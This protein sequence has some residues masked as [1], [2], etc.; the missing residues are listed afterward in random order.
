MKLRPNTLITLG[1]SAVF[2]LAAVFLARGWINNSVEAEFRTA[3]TLSEAVKVPL[4]K[5]ITKPIVVADLNLNFGDTLT[6]DKL[7]VVEY[8]EN[9]IPK[10]AYTNIDDLLADM[11]RRV[12]REH[13]ARFEPI[14]PHKISG[15]NGRRALSQLIAPGMRAA[16]FRITPTSGVGGYIL[17]NDRVDVVFVR[18][19]V[20]DLYALEKD[21]VVTKIVMQNVKV[22]GVDL[23]SNQQSETTALRQSV[24]LE[25]NNEQAQKL[26][27][28]QNSGEL[29]L[30]LR[31]AGEADIAPE[32]TAKLK[33]I[34]NKFVIQSP[35]LPP[36]A[37]ASIAQHE[38]NNLPQVTIIRGNDRNQISVM[39]D[40]GPLEETSEIKAYQ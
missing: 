22:L 30:T 5:E 25:V 29:I 4:V 27:L 15:E 7:L 13:I 17:P 11:P 26:F 38:N 33:D 31:A 1:A 36:S 10:G 12:L 23:N 32:Y 3:Q 20:R 14:L 18:N 16:T 6:A 19:I 39:N 35:Q 40:V 37:Q 21:S 9:A 34:F 2:G 28:L 24:T 8:P